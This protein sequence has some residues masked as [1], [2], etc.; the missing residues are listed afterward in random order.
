MKKLVFLAVTLIIF[1]V[2]IQPL[3]YGQ[4]LAAHRTEVR[5][6][7][8]RLTFIS[9][10]LQ[11]EIA[12][13]ELVRG[14]LFFKVTEPL[15]EDLKVFFHLVPPGQNQTVLNADFSPHYQTRLW[16]VNQIVEA[17]PFV[18]GIPLN[19]EPGEYDIR[20][21]L[22]QIVREEDEVLYLREPYTNPEIENFIIGRITVTETDA[23]EAEASAELDL[24]DLG[25]EA[26]I[27]FWETLGAEVEAMN[28]SDEGGQSLSAIRA[29]ILPGQAEYPG[30]ILNNFFQLQP[31]K[32]DWATYDLLR[33]NLFLPPENRGGQ[34]LIMKITDSLGRSFQKDLSLTAGQTNRLELPLVDLSGAINVGRIE[35][36]KFFLV[37]PR[38]PFTFFI[39]GFRLISRGQ[40]TGSPAVTFVRLEAPDRIARG[41]AFRVRVV[42]Q[43]TR[44]IFPDHKMFVHV[45][46]VNDMA[47]RVGTDTRLAPPIRSWPL[48]QEVAVDSG[49]LMVAESAPPGTYI[50][51]AGLY[52]VAESPGRGYVKIDDWDAYGDQEVANIFQPTGPVDYI[53]Q[54]YTNLEI[55]DWEVGTI[56]VE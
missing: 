20:A 55:Q 54:P 50:V 47:G 36:I 37:N 33:L 35:Q 32:A 4:K 45:Y 2:L 3:L 41:R 9:F 19:F 29:T 21:G 16:D 15:E 53:K 26:E 6:G 49:P 22:L 44:P 39:S 48:N 23:P 25:N 10:N 5:E 43:L 24:F 52:I 27:I 28:Y 7:D 40:P 17:G 51:R 18:L 56:E 13:G 11:T 34:R 31:R 8:P 30:V 38:N 42:F 14:S 12:Q 1:P 46:R